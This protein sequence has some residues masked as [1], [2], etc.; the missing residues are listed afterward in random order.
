MSYQ[1]RP[2]IDSTPN[3]FTLDL[4]SSP[5]HYQPY[6]YHKNNNYLESPS[7][8]RKEPNLSNSRGAIPTENINLNDNHSFARNYKGRL[9]N[10]D[11]QE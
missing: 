8:T 10:A 6:N 5:N 11:P 3:P 1:A 2:P 7:Y 4:N 9:F